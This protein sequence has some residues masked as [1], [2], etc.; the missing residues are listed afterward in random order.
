[1]DL[2]VLSIPCVM[3]Q[4]SDRT[5]RKGTPEPP[6]TIS[7]TNPPSPVLEKLNNCL[8]MFTNKYFLNMIYLEE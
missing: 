4:F 6:T 3:Q 5:S 7:P 1:M 2:E 8:S